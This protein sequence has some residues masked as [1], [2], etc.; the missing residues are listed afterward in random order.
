MSRLLSPPLTS[1]IW[2]VEQIAE[3]GT[4]FLLEAIAAEGPQATLREVV[5]PVLVARASTG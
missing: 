3:R 5:A 2:D 1:T 4:E